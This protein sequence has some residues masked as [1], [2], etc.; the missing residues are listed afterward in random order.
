MP[1]QS[2]REEPHHYP[3][4]ARGFALNNVFQ[5]TLSSKYWATIWQ[6]TG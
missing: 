6:I 1:G 5:L 3:G 2:N 4:A